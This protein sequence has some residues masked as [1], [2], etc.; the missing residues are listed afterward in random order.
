MIKRQTLTSQ[1]I[2]Y[3]LN[4]IKTGKV[5]P[6]EKL[7]TE[8]ALTETLG[9]SRTCVREAMKSLESLRRIAVRPRVGA[10]VLEPSSAALF[11]AEHL[12]TAAHLQRTDFLI[13]FRKILEVGL[14][15]LAAE[16]ADQEDLRAMEQAIDDHRRAVE[17]GQLAY[18]A[19]IAFHGAI[20]DASKNPIAIMVFETILEPLIEQRRLTNAVP[21]AAEAGLRD[22]L[23][24]FAAIKKRN[25]EKARALMRAHMETAEHYWRIASAGIAVEEMAAK[26]ESA[27]PA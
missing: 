4:L 7:P 3:V 27:V 21:N 12:S 8:K 25:P 24:I 23:K 20:A 5:K 14:A 22:H 10:M 17:T 11:N 2:E 26:L 9:V 1:V 13:E 19:D 6:G 15:P 18:L 16:K